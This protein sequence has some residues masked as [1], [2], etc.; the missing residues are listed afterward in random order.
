M[1]QYDLAVYYFLL[2]LANLADDR[3]YPYSNISNF[4]EI[5]W[6]IAWL[7]L[8]ASVFGLFQRVQK[9]RGY[10][11]FFIAIVIALPLLLTIDIFSES[12][13]VSNVPIFIFSLCQITFLLLASKTASKTPLL[14]KGAI[15]FLLALPFFLLI[16]GGFMINIF[17][18]N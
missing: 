18:P 17:Y 12:S 13:V 6:V 14:S 8:I 16:L 15:S 11:I 2:Y 7:Q 5:L 3:I 1:N 4:L 9:K 10:Q